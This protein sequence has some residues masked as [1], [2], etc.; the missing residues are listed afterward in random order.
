MS[1]PDFLVWESRQDQNVLKVVPL[2][3]WFLNSYNNFGSRDPTLLWNFQNPLWG[4]YGYFLEPQSWKTHFLC[5]FPLPSLKKFTTQFWSLTQ[6][7]NILR[8]VSNK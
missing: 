7:Y 8:F 3:L 1:N 2:S 5:F 6:G 4:G